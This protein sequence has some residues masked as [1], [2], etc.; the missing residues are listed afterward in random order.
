M[1]YS[2]L[3]LIP[4]IAGMGETI[5]MTGVPNR[6]IPF[7]NLVIG[8]AL[9]MTLCSTN[10]KSCVIFGLY[11]GLSASGLV[12]SSREFNNCLN[13]RSPCDKKKYNTKKYK[14]II[15]EESNNYNDDMNS[16]DEN[17]DDN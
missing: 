15:N 7:I 5:R 17:I 11:T 1:E 14:D 6:Y 10:L 4:L 12:R 13:T 3:I 16:D 2:Y 9:G 8:L